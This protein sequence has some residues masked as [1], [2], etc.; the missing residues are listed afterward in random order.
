MI[1]H[2]LIHPRVP[3]ISS[4]I[5]LSQ[6][7]EIVDKQN[8]GKLQNTMHMNDLPGN[9]E[10]NVDSDQRL[11]TKSG[12]SDGNIANE[13]NEST[14]E[15]MRDSVHSTTSS[16]LDSTA[17][18]P[19]TSNNSSLNKDEN[20]LELSTETQHDDTSEI[21]GGTRQPNEEI[22]PNVDL[23]EKENETVHEETEHT[24]T[25]HEENI[26]RTLPEGFEEVT[27]VTDEGLSEVASDS[28]HPEKKRKTQEASTSYAEEGVS[29][30]NDRIE[31]STKIIE[32][33]E[34]IIHSSDCRKD[35]KIISEHIYIY[36]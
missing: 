27:K 1:C 18:E 30:N 4:S 21:A 36:I 2:V 11:T 23:V 14:L 20:T 22:T 6:E 17:N 34:V 7:Q 3:I 29:N 32:Q 24:M 33:E 26:K 31:E 16:T 35:K 13:N 15:K 9:V 28:I 10:I 12:Q 25:E 19:S 8:N 5:N